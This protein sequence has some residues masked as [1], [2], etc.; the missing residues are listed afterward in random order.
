[1]AKKKPTERSNRHGKIPEGWEGQG[2]QIPK[3]LREELREA[4][5]EFGN[6]G[7]KVIGTA[8]LAIFMSLDSTDRDTI[9]KYVFQKTFKSPEGL[10]K[11][12][13]LELMKMLINERDKNSTKIIEPIWSVDEVDEN[14]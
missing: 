8:A 14:Q 5:G 7:V 11:R 12:R 6:G 9:C 10:D 2:L 3:W 13:V 1:M 4:A